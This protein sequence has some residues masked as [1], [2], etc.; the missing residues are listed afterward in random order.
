VISCINV[1][2]PISIA[3]RKTANINV[4]LEGLECFLR[5]TLANSQNYN[6]KRCYY[7]KYYIA[8]Q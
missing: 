5:T 4:K 3:R 6:S 8:V 1:I 2:E 7:K